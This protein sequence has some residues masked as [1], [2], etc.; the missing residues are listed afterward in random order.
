MAQSVVGLQGVCVLFPVITI[1]SPYMFSWNFKEIIIISEILKDGDS[2]PTSGGDL[3]LHHPRQ[4]ART[5]DSNSAT[6]SAREAAGDGLRE[7]TSA[8]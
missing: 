4:E 7:L 5:E 2:G 3:Q 8:A 6:E 1:N